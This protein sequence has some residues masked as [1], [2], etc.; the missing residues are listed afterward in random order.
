MTLEILYHKLT[1]EFSI[2]ASSMI[3]L[4]QRNKPD[5]DKSSFTLVMKTKDLAEKVFREINGKPILNSNIVITLKKSKE[6]MQNLKSFYFKV[7]NSKEPNNKEPN[8][9]DTQFF[10]Q[11]FTQYGKIVSI[12]LAYFK[13][14]FL[15]YGYVSFEDGSFNASSGHDLSLLKP[16]QEEKLEFGN[17]QI[18][19]KP[20]ISQKLRQSDLRTIHMINFTNEITADNLEKA[21]SDKKFE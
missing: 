4:K 1:N 9:Y 8:Q 15:D 10:Q 21:K 17:V 12:K 11:F 3:Q 13:N 5:P 7:T 2:D 16:E 14:Q 18:T 6:C 19:I 20:F